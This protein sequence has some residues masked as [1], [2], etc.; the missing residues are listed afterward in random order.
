[1]LLSLAALVRL[2]GLDTGL[3]F[4]EIQ[5]C[6]ELLRRSFGDLVTAYPSDNNHPGYTW[7]A[8]V[9]SRLLGEHPWV[10][11]LPAYLAGIGAP[12]ALYRFILRVDG[13]S[14]AL[15]TSA[16]LALSSHAV[17]FSQNARGYSALLLFTI[18]STDAFQRALTEEKGSAWR[19]YALW[20]GLATWMH[21]TAVFVALGHAL[22]A[23]PT[24]FGSRRVGPLAALAGAG[25]VSLLLH[26][27]LLAPMWRFFSAAET[28]R[29][30]WDWTRPFWTLQESLRS[31]G[32]PSWILVPLLIMGLATLAAGLR[33]LA[34]GDR[35]LPALL[36]VPPILGGAIL[37]A[38][39]RNLWPR[40]FFFATGFFLWAAVEGVGVA[41]ELIARGFR[42][43]GT[44]PVFR[45][46]ALVLMGCVL[47][48]RLPAVW[49]L[50]KQDYE[51]ALRVVRE[52]AKP[53]DRVLA[54]GLAVLP[55]TTFYK[56]TLTE[57]TGRSFDGFLA[58]L[59][60]GRSLWI[61]TTFPVFTRS[62]DPALTRRLSEE[63]R[64][65]ERLPGLIGGGDLLIYRASSETGR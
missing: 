45:R 2:P 39:G 40:F 53:G 16:L 64:L 19:S 23:L 26:A 58:D 65:V 30:H 31:F 6:V 9:T 25:G 54:A 17:M 36:F 48:W 10:L 61:L 38:S 1:M 46:C 37:V 41:A 11:R 55:Y 63:A 49:T 60:P 33:R 5:M 14:N 34:R 12:L 4:D 47:A 32:L 24:Y 56:P 21:T 22:V 43:P 15:A 20:M 18:L 35:R 51:G 3:W 13:R 44:A 29:G 57:V 59:K 62:R 7:S 8:W 52:R 50:P 27:P 42:R 28:G